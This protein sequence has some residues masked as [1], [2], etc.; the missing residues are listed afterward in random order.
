MKFSASLFTLLVFICSYGLQAQ[1]DDHKT[2]EAYLKKVY[3]AYESGQAESMWKYYTASASEITPDG[4]LSSGKD[5]LKAGWDEMMKVVDERP[6]F[7][8]KLTTSRLITP[9]VA[10]VTWDSNADIKI[11][12]Q[13]VGGPAACVAVLHKIKGKWQIEFDGMTPVLSMPAGN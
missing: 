5:V 7:T 9:E 12:G 2:F 8:Y 10:L 13:Q 4:H 11:Q 6:K 3:D 1:S